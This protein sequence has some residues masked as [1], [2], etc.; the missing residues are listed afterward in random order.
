MHTEAG[1]N[2][3]TF[4]IDPTH[5][6]KTV[7]HLRVT[8]RAIPVTFSAIRAQRK[9]AKSEKH[10]FCSSEMI[11]DPEAACCPPAV[12]RRTSEFW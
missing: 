8:K 9:K 2:P 4:L 12:D 6:R 7:T 10:D 3:A 5:L 1:Q 11:P